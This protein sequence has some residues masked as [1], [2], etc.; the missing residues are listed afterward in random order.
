MGRIVAAHPHAIDFFLKGASMKPENPTA[1]TKPN[2]HPLVT[3]AEREGSPATTLR[4]LRKS[5]LL[6]TILYA[7]MAS[8]LACADGARGP[9]SPS[10]Q[11]V[12]AEV[13]LTAPAGELGGAA[14]DATSTTS[15]ARSGG[16][17][18]TKECSQF[19]GAPG[20]FC[21]VTGSNVSAIEAGSRI[22]YAE[23]PGPTTLDTDIVL[24]LPGPGNNKAFGHCFLVLATGLGECTLTGGTGKFTW[25]EARADVSYLGGPDWEWAGTFSFRPHD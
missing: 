10:G 22:I 14:P 25:F 2:V 19:T 7:G 1:G 12:G 3:R 9:T 8:T 6:G 24:D 4:H 16:F 15:K 18:L 13:A 23:S 21:T 20:S 17:Y 5:M 11:P